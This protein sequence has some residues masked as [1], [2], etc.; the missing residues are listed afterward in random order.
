MGRLRFELR[1]GHGG[2]AAFA[3]ELVDE[4]FVVR[5]ELLLGLLVGAGDVAGGVDGDAAAEDAVLLQRVLVQVHVRGEARRLAADHRQREV[6]SV[7][8][9][10]DDRFRRT[11]DRD[12]D[13][14]AVR[15]SGLRIDLLVRERCARRPFPRDR[16]FGTDGGEEGEL[17]FEQAAVVRQVESEQRERLGE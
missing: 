7:S 2:P 4:L 11:A 1:A 13:R 3:S 15:A 16:A 12:P 17:F 10:A 14:Q 6:E 8:R 9:R 5:P